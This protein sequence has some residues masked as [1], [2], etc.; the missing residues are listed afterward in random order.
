MEKKL[1]LAQRAFLK[2]QIGRTMEK[3][4][5]FAE[6]VLQKEEKNSTPGSEKNEK[7][8]LPLDLRLYT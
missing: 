5:E 3:S 6:K 7:Y 2:L 1:T 4:P 8:Y